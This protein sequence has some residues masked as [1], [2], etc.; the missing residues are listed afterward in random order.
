ME[1]T[2]LVIAVLGL[3]VAGIQTHFTCKQAHLGQ[4][5]AAEA[6]RLSKEIYMLRD[7]VDEQKRRADKA[8]A[9]VASVVELVKTGGALVRLVSEAEMKAELQKRPVFRTLEEHHRFD[10]SRRSSPSPRA[11]ISR[12]MRFQAQFPGISLVTV[13]VSLWIMLLLGL[14]KIIFAED[15]SVW[16]LVRGMF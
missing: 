15:K 8:E 14:V 9:R 6:E 7:A 3:G 13:Q 1:I 12:G 11:T 10:L 16:D 2:L 5:S 4:V